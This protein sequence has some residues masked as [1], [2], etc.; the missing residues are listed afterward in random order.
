M[1]LIFASTVS[2]ESFKSNG[3]RHVRTVPYHPASNGM[4]ERVL[5]SFKLGMKKL[6]TGSLEA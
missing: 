2:K 5:Q 6:N 1:G 4:A 3:I